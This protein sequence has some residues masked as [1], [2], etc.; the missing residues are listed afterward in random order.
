MQV[1]STSALRASPSG[2]KYTITA[3]YGKH[4]LPY[5]E[6]SFDILAVYI[7]NLDIWYHIRMEDMQST[8]IN[9]YP[10]RQNPRGFYEDGKEDWSV[11]DR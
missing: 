4:K 11:Y 2:G 1:K 6:A 3:V 9:L 5:P 10:H 7:A 8:S